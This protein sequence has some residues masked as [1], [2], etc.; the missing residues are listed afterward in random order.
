ML[1]RFSRG[2]I[3]GGPARPARK[4]EPHSSPRPVHHLTVAAI[5]P[6][7]DGR[8]SRPRS[9][10]QND[11]RRARR[12]YHLRIAAAPQPQEGAW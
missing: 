1:H 7:L 12:G 9:A 5:I 2:P 4:H 8:E 3:L 11:C 6:D 10:E